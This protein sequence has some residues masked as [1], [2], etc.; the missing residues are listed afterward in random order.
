MPLAGGV[1][2][3]AAG[4]AMGRATGLPDEHPRAC[5]RWTAT[6][7]QPL[8][9]RYF[10]SMRRSVHRT[11]QHLS[12]LMFSTFSNTLRISTVDEVILP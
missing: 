10:G 1:L 5:A 3:A 8:Q 9:G 12:A 7:A 11:R 6:C 2:A 4:G